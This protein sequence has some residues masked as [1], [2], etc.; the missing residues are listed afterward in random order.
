MSDQQQVSFEE[1]LL[2]RLAQRLGV[3]TAQIEMLQLQI[4]QRDAELEQ[5]RAQL[6]DIDSRLSAPNVNGEASHDVQS[7]I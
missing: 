5:L 2:N 3:A 7:V 4:E 6:A 1:V